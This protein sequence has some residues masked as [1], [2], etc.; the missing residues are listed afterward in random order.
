MPS[1]EAYAAVLAELSRLADA[2]RL[3]RE[4]INR[5]VLVL[6]NEVG[7]LERHVDDV[8]RWQWIRLGIEMG[9]I[10]ALLLYHFG[11]NR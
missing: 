6:A 5:A 2:W 7:S 9:V 3:H 4:S 10:I 8:R 1:D 11:V